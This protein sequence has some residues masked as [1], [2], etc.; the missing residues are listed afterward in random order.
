MN[1]DKIYIFKKLADVD[2]LSHAY[3]F[4]GEAS[5]RK[6]IFALSLANYLENKEFKLLEKNILE[7][8]FV[9]SPDEKGIIG[10]DES[11]KIGSFLYQKPVLSKK[12]TVI[13]KDADSLTPEAQNATLKIVEDSPEGSL[14]IFIAKDESSLLPPL[15]SRLQKIYFP[16]TAAPKKADASILKMG[17]EEIIE[18]DRIDE[19]FKSLIVELRKDPVKNISK[20]KEAL[21][22]LTLIK[23][24]NT[25]KKLQLKCLSRF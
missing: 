1:Q 4:F 9:I 12:R 5:E 18:K 23:R 2:K 19:Y 11:K 13:I 24:F 21:K 25:N 7:E 14:L 16:E 6:I 22:R 8:C 15:A 20:L 3:L 17:L 10:I